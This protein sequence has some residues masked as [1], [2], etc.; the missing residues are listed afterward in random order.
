VTVEGAVTAARVLGSTV[1]LVGDEQVLQGHLA[2]H[3]VAGW[4]WHPTRAGG[5]RDERGPMAALRKKSTPRS[6]SAWTW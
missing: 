4:A 5:G 2:R 1:I 6:R 3:G